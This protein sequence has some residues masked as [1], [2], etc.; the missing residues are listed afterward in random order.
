LLS[1]QCY[2][3]QHN[4]TVHSGDKPYKCDVCG[5]RFPDSTTYDKHHAKHGADKP[6]KCDQCPK[7]FNHKADLRRHSHNHDGMPF[8]C[9]ECG[10]GFSRM[11]QMLKHMATNIHK[12]VIKGEKTP[13]KKKLEPVNLK[14][15]TSNETS[16]LGN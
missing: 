10:K 2:L 9:K 14:P 15:A 7:A 3:T 13:R 8:I 11:D 1:G 5:K 16:I 12:R 4:R 6:F